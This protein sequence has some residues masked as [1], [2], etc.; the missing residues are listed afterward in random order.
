MNLTG[1][2]RSSC[3]W[4]V[5]I[6]L[7]IK[8]LD[9]Q[10]TPVHLTRD[11][12]EQHQAAHRRRNPLGQVPA[13]EVEPDRWLAQSMAILAYLDER[14]P[15]P[16]LLPDDIW[17]RARARQ[18]AEMINAG[19]Q[20][21]QN[22]AVLKHLEVSGGVDRH[23]WARH[24]ITVGLDAV[25]ATAQEQSSRFLVGDRPSYADLCLVPQL[26]NA[27]RF[28]CDLSRWPRLLAAESAALA[29]PAFHLTCPEQQPDAVRA[30]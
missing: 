13:L 26:Y 25:E 3:T 20:P 4:R 7:A 23:D 8:G 14:Y 17:E 29:L 16:P 9:H 21:L 10:S 28:D 24:Y 12:G 5:R 11:G 27:R 22:L 19:I 6:A 1:Y 18:L 15:D 2:W 30:A